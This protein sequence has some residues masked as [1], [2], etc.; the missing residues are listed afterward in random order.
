MNENTEK[1]K[2]YLYGFAEAMMETINRYDVTIDNF[3]KSQ[4]ELLSVVASIIE[5][6]GEDGKIYIHPDTVASVE[7]KYY[8]LSTKRDAAGGIQ[9]TV[10]FIE[11]PD[12]VE[13]NSREDIQAQV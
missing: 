8:K 13:Q 11:E 5:E 7:D 1:F 3:V 6:C 12:N 4:T 10:E 9:Y 2:E